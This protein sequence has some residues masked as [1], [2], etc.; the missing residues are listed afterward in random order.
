MVISLEAGARYKWCE[1]GPVNATATPA[2]F[3]SLKPKVFYGSYISFLSCPG[4]GG[5]NRAYVLSVCRQ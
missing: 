1:Y 5:I 2:S 3:V 4:W